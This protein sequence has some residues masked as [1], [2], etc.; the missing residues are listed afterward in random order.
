MFRN[1]SRWIPRPK[2]D[3]WLRPAELTWAKIS[4]G[5]LDPLDEQRQRARY[6]GRPAAEAAALLWTNDSSGGGLAPP[7]IAADRGPLRCRRLRLVGLQDAGVVL[8]R[9]EMLPREGGGRSG[10][11]SEGGV[12]GAAGEMFVTTVTF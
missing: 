2:L 9:Q 5:E 8:L 3:H 10:W 12:H 11:R 1:A 6:P 4:G 7:A